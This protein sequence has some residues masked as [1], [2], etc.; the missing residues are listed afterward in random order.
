MN[1]QL[2]FEGNSLIF[3]RQLE[4]ILHEKMCY[5]YMNLTKIMNSL[6]YIYL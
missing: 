2:T 3:V 5:F 1:C 6:V 4:N